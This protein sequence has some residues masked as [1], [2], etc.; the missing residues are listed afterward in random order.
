MKLKTEDLVRPDIFIVLFLLFIL[1]GIL[2]NHLMEDLG[3]EV[4]I[5]L[6]IFT[7]L[8]LAFYFIGGRYVID[9]S[10]N[11]LLPLFVLFAFL[12]S[13]RE[14][15]LYS[16]PIV[17]VIVLIY[18]YWDLIEVHCEKISL[19]GLALILINLGIVG[20]LPLLEVG[21]RFE[22]QTVVLLFGYS[23]SLLGINYL[24]FRDPK[25]GV[26][27]A[28]VVFA[29]MMLYGFRSYL[30]VLVLSLG[31]QVILLKRA[32]LT[33]IIPLAALALAIVV[34]GGSFI[35]SNLDQDWHLSASSLLFYRIGF[36][37][38]MFDLA[39]DSARMFGVLHGQ[40]WTMPSTSPMIG[41]LLAGGGNITTTI[42]GPLVLDGGILELPL[43]AFIGASLNSLYQR[44]KAYPG[45]VPLYAIFL[46]FL[47][48]SIEISPVPII[49]FTL[50]FI[51]IIINRKNNK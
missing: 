25:R 26:I 30:I 32:R 47:L 7:F 35:V 1:V 46:S 21:L 19:V 18:H 24:Y 22:S 12:M 14:F 27:Y 3:H 36:T 38:H 16:I 33:R 29:S 17:A 28:V 39:C 44:S 11:V 13:Y 49:F 37:T 34:F 4:S 41:E 10:P 31:V 15:G 45:H 2:S 5:Y 9:V 43:M 40:V 8:G 23:L 42:M 20:V 50:I 48:I 6:P 51:V